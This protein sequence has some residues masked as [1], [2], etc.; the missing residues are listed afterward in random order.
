MEVIMKAMSLWLLTLLLLVGPPALGATSHFDSVPEMIEGLNDFTSD[1]GSFRVLR[2][3]PLQIQLVE[4]VVAGDFPE[5]IRENIQRVIIYGV[6]RAFVHT[7]IDTITVSAVPG[8]LRISDWEIEKLLE[9]YRVTVTTTRTDALRYVQ[10]YCK[11]ASMQDLVEDRT[12]GDY[13]FPN[14]WA[15]CFEKLQYNDQGGPGLAVFFEN[16][17]EK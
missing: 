4:K 2:D 7:D 3:K 9:G 8:L 17:R 5:V 1:D 6:Y 12:Y 11:V 10:K 13:V 15:E 14:V 16:F